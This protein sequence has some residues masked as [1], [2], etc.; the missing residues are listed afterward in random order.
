MKYKGW[1][2]EAIAKDIGVDPKQGIVNPTNGEEE[3]I[4][5]YIAK[6][7]NKKAKSGK[8]AEDYKN[9]LNK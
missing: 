5:T 4:A 9:M 6:A 7:T 2:T 8:T 3:T 1:T